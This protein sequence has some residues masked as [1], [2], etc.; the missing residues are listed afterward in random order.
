M[1][2]GIIKYSIIGCTCL[3]FLICF[4]CRSGKHSDYKFQEY[5]GR[6]DTVSNIRKDS[7]ASV[8]E[9]NDRS[10]VVTKERQYLRS[11][12]FDSLG[13]ISNIQESWRDYG[14]GRMDESKGRQGTVSVSAETTQQK[15]TSGSYT[16]ASGESESNTDSRP[17]QGVEWGYI[18]LA[19]LFV[20]GIIRY[21]KN[22]RK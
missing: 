15:S 13:R 20:F 5:A 4:S 14:S 7:S 12:S 8:S 18:A 10:T 16:K 1:K 3:F 19:A 17:V 9:T 11:V 21:L 6:I 22:I 2:Y